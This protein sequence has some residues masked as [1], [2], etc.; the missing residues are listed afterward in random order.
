MNYL[1][2][3]ECTIGQSESRRQDWR[4][5]A[6]LLDDEEEDGELFVQGPVK[7]YFG[8]VE[9]RPTGQTG[10]KVKWKWKKTLALRPA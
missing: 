10:L 5:A 1:I 6:V 8:Q 4:Q 9:F 3:F 2:S 7:F